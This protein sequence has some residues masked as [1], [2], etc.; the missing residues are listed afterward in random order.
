M[1]AA[2]AK[3]LKKHIIYEPILNDTVLTLAR[4]S[5]SFPNRAAAKLISAHVK[6]DCYA[7]AEEA[8]C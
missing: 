1:A 5:N 7:R 2:S 3:N 4:I 6:C 8:L